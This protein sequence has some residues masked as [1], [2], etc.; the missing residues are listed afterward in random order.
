MI[1]T[2]TMTI[3]RASA[4]TQPL[5]DQGQMP[6]RGAMVQ[7]TSLS[8]A[9]YRRADEEL[10]GMRLKQYVALR[11]IRSFEGL[12]Q[13]VLS[14]HLMLDANNT[15]L[16]LNELEAAGWA[17][18]VRD[19]ADRRRHRVE[20]TDEGAKALDAAEE[21]MDSVEDDVL[22]ALTAKERSTLTKLLAKAAE[23]LAATSARDADLAR[24]R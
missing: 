11:A 9:V 17:T 18:R 5:Y 1:V 7:I 15:V 2:I 24:R 3:N 12:T 23:G 6:E 4:I 21:A 22:R 13:Q 10:L 20:L 16:M 14:E 8:R 19:P